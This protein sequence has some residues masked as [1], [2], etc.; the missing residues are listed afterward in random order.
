MEIKITIVPD[1]GQSTSRDFAT[2]DEAVNYL[3]PMCDE[4][5]EVT[6]EELD[7]NLSEQE[8][9]TT[10]LTRSRPVPETKHPFEK[11][12][13]VICGGSPE[14]PEGLEGE[15]T[16]LECEATGRGRYIYHTSR[17]TDAWLPGHW[18]SPKPAPVI[19]K[20][21]LGRLGF[22]QS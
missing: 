12:Q 1:M 11:G 4:G 9:V 21:I 16:V 8:L 17:S 13:V 2:P 19:P 20:G 6:D 10:P 18:L 14:I 22:G 3:L 5:G 7:R 15:H